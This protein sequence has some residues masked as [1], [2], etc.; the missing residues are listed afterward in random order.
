MSN[1]SQNVVSEIID[2]VLDSNAVIFTDQYGIAWIAPEGN[3][4]GID[5]INSDTF[6]Q[7]LDDMCYETLEGY[8]PSNATEKQVQKVLQAKARRSGNHHSLEINITRHNKAILHD[9]G[10]GAVRITDKKWS[11]VK[12]PPIVFRKPTG[13]QVQVKPKRGGD[14]KELLKFF[15]ITSES[16]QLLILCYIITLFIPGIQYP[17]LNLHG[18]QGAGKSLLMQFVKAI[19][20]H[21]VLDTGLSTPKD[22]E[23]LALH[24]L[25]NFLLF[26]DNLSNMKEPLSDALCRAVTGSTFM[27]RKLY[28]NSEVFAV[29]FNRPIILNGLS[30]VVTKS[31]LHDRSLVM[32]LER[33]TAENRK[34]PSVLW[35][36]FNEAK[37]YILGA[38]FD[39]IIKAQA[40]FG[41]VKQYKV[42][43]RMTEFDHWGCAIAEVLGY[44]QDK[45]RQARKENMLLQH[46]H[47]IEASAVGQAVVAFLQDKPGW[48]GSPA[49]LYGLLE[50]IWARLH[51]EKPKGAPHGPLGREINT[52][53]P[54]LFAKGIKTTITRGDQ[55][56]IKFTKLADGNDSKNG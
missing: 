13:Q 26:Y 43:S 30:Q 6:V 5:E 15:N 40:V 52:L 28:K 34:E 50:P 17:V 47:A 16:E 32:Q 14:V 46:G 44:G 37:P 49:T 12:N 2:M 38:I 29:K 55:R 56:N 48:S 54:N 9:L 23:D 10:N 4:N 36:E 21:S 7:W 3:G 35:A 41:K 27:T 19:T 39:T 31:D 45:F 8:V 22:E 42:L 18:T 25:H 53:T 51:L 24:A 11:I 20:D 33:I 1:K